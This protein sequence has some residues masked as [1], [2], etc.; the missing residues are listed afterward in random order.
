MTT[1]YFIRHAES[2]ILVRDGR[3]RPLTVK[4]LADRK[5]VTEYLQD[6]YISTALSSPF[7]RAIDTIADFANNN[8]LKIEIIEDFREQK[9]STGMGRDNPSHYAFLEQQWADF[10]YTVSDGEN[11]SN[12]QKRNI[13][14]LNDVLMR[15]ED[16]NIVI[17]THGT[18]LSTIINYY[19]NTY[20][21]NDFMSM[22]NIQP[23][24]VKM[25]FNKNCCNNIEKIDLCEMRVCK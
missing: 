16:K 22:V 21:F 2:D 10:S 11:L 23:W 18:A 3:I 24:V 12:V 15:Y 14:A 5:L 4:G 6:K 8:G 7:K 19:D 13:E 9:S 20:G 25:L 1:I 17:G